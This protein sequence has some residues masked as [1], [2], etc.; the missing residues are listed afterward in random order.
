VKLIEFSC[1]AQAC[2]DA[3]AKRSPSL[4]RLARAYTLAPWIPRRRAWGWVASDVCTQVAFAPTAALAVVVAAE[5]GGVS[6]CRSRR[7]R[8]QPP[9]NLHRAERGLTAGRCIGRALTMQATAD[10]YDLT[11]DAY[12]QQL[13]ARVLKLGLACN[14]SVDFKAHRSLKRRRQ[15]ELG[16]GDRS[17]CRGWMARAAKSLCRAAGSFD[18]SE[19]RLQALL[20]PA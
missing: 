13:P 4:Q 8:S 17:G 3:R 19:Y 9:C 20:A 2:L 6:S 16:P 7:A 12:N 15:A 5:K 14:D 10:R 1:A 18:R 11:N